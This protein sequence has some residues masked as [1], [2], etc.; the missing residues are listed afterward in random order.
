MNI[1]R[2]I[3]SLIVRCKST[4]DYCNAVKMADE[5]HARDG[6]RYYVVAGATDGRL[7][8]MDRARFRA[9]KKANRLDYSITLQSL[10]EKSFYFTAHGNGTGALTK[11]GIAEKRRDFYRWRQSIFEQRQKVKAALRKQRR[12]PLA[13]FFSFKPKKR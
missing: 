11:E 4:I 3:Q 8:V 6:Q 9:L 1:K 13:R 7:L 2:K 12:S 5:Y 10:T